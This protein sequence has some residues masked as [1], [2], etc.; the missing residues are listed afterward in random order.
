M[1]SGRRGV[2]PLVGITE[3]RSHGRPQELKLKH[4]LLVNGLISFNEDF[5]LLDQKGGMGLG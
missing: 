1:T 4:G 3:S 5:S 2:L